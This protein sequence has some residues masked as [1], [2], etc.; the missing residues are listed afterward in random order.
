MSCN[1]IS[2]KKYVPIKTSFFKRRPTTLVCNRLSVKWNIKWITKIKS[3]A[4][5]VCHIA[6]E[7]TKW[8]NATLLKIKMDCCYCKLSLF[9]I[10]VISAVA[11]LKQVYHYIFGNFRV[12]LLEPKTLEI[13]GIGISWDR[14]NI[15][16]RKKFQTFCCF[17]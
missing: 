17:L 14:I 2:F 12:M 11:V 13:Q 7:E 1:A 6:V 16:N 10:R 15:V 8:K 9:S 5:L 3:H 4:D